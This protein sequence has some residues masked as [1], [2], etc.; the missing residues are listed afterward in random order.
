MCVYV[1]HTLKLILDMGGVSDH[2]RF[3]QPRMF[4]MPQ[5]ITLLGQKLTEILSENKKS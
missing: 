1:Y 2:K 3:G 4:R 5:F